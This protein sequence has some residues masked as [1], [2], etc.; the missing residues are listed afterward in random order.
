M[1]TV[2][3]FC[4]TDGFRKLLEDVA[5]TAQP[6]EVPGPLSVYPVGTTMPIRVEVPEHVH[7]RLLRKDLAE[8]YA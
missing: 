8:R 6:H 1:R 2:T 3:I 5:A 4:S 7:A